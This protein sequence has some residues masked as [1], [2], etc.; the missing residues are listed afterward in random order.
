MISDINEKLCEWGVWSS[1]SRGTS[2]SSSTTTARRCVTDRCSQTNLHIH[3]FTDML[4]DDTPDISDDKN[5]LLVDPTEV[6]LWKEEKSYVSVYLRTQTQHSFVSA[7][8][9][10]RL[11]T[12][13][14]SITP[15]SPPRLARRA[16]RRNVLDTSSTRSACIS[17]SPSTRNTAS[18]SR[19]TTPTLTIVRRRAHTLFH[20]TVRCRY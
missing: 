19:S 7:S 4:P 6:F 16:S 11:S 1:L 2:R 17:H 3:I 18:P 12:A 10:C 20:Q 8:A 14:T 5:I 9:S 13:R 15:R